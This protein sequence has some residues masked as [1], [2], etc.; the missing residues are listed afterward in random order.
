M[1]VENIRDKIILYAAL[2]WGLGHVTRSI[3]I[4]QQLIDQQ[5]TIIIACDSKQKILFMSY[6][7]EIR[8]EILSGYNFNF[9]NKGKWGLDLL[10]SSLNFFKAISNEN[11]FIRSFELLNKIDLVISDHR[12]G[13]YSRIKPSY[14]ITHQLN[15]PIS[16]W[17]YFIQLWHE[18]KLHKFTTLWILDTAQY[19]FAGKLSMP[20]KHN[21]L[22]YI[23]LYSR[24]KCISIT[25]LVYDYLIVISGPSSYSST[26]ISELKLKIDF[27]N[28]SVAVLYPSNYEL[29]HES[30]FKYFEANNLKQN[31]ELFFKSKI[32]IS[33]FGYSTLMDLVLTNKR[34]LLIPTK[35]QKEQHYLAKVPN[36]LVYKL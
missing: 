7:P 10:K 36:N 2:D 31:D 15:L 11:K 19:K 4:I 33:R 5:N 21:S 3:G 16:K 32:I 22:E 27:S 34:G 24:F 29:E 8:Y 12:Y 18:V 26:F 14:F 1:K 13:F 6:F 28:K 25:N 9:S 17:Y 20:I 23:G 30:G 35:G